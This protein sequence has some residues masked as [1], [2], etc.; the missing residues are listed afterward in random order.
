MKLV[1]AFILSAAWT[2]GGGFLV[3]RIDDLWRK[4]EQRR[5]G[6]EPSRGFESIISHLYN[7]A[8]QT[9]PGR[10]RSG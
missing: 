7:D 2:F 8:T 6:R 4:L 10:D 3:R 9:R 5:Q 1:V